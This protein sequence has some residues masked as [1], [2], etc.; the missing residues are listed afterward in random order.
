MGACIR[1]HGSPENRATTPVGYMTM[2]TM[3][4]VT[5]E[6]PFHEQMLWYPKGNSFPCVV[7]DHTST[8][9][10]VENG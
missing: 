10:G 1:P 8:I 9:R 3:G 2:A 5:I 7:D 6:D 4:Y